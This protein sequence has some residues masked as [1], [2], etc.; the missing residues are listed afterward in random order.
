MEQEISKTLHWEYSDKEYNN[1][2]YKISVNWEFFEKEFVFNE[3]IKDVI[4][5]L[6]TYLNSESDNEF[7]FTVNYFKWN[8]KYSF[9]RIT[10][11][12]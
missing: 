2:Y 10:R 12:I 8:F 9:F 6:Q 7:T 3:I 4:H 1:K 5:N 11:S